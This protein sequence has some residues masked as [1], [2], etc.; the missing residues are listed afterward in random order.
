MD[1]PEQIVAGGMAG[2]TSIDF[3]CRRQSHAR[4]APPLAYFNAHPRAHAPCHAE[5]TGN[6]VSLEATLYVART[7]PMVDLRGRLQ[8]LAGKEDNP[9][10]EALAVETLQRSVQLHIAVQAAVHTAGVDIKVAEYEAHGAMQA[11]G[12]AARGWRSRRTLEQVVNGCLVAFFVKGAPFG[13]RTCTALKLPPCLP[14]ITATQ[15]T[16]PVQFHLLRP[17]R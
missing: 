17:C 6:L 15:R 2:S 4:Q 14:G 11:R 12:R 1:N 9:E 7:Q 5:C 13:R 8:F 3:T 16:S 10:V